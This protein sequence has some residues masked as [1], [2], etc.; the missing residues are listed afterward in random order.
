MKATEKAKELLERFIRAT[1]SIDE[2][3]KWIEDIDC[4]KQCALIC[5]DEMIKQNGEIYLTINSVANPDMIAYY[6][7]V[8]GYLF[9]VKTEIENLN[10]RFGLQDSNICSHPKDRVWQKG[11]EKFCQE[12]KSWI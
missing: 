8:N 10:N 5:C 11:N 1:K 2:N 12:C 3:G 7:K 9:A 4:A 6:G